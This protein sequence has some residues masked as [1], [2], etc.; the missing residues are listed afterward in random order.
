MRL[1]NIQCWKLKT[2]FVPIII[3]FSSAS[4]C[5]RPFN[6][7]HW[8]DIRRSRRE[9]L[10]VLGTD[11]NRYRSSQHTRWACHS[12]IPFHSIPPFHSI[13]PFHHSIPLNI[14]ICLDSVERGMEQWNGGMVELWNGQL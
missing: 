6:Y 12:T 8:L 2:H 5:A 10:H 1:T 3:Y 14:D 13:I 4:V 9:N 7:C 11:Y